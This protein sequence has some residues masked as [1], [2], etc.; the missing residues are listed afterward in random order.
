MNMLKYL[1]SFIIL[2]FFST[3]VVYADDHDSKKYYDKDGKKYHEK[4]WGGKGKWKQCPMKNKF[5]QCPLM[6]M[7]PPPMMGMEGPFTMIEAQGRLFLYNKKNG[8]V[9][10]CNAF[11]KSC[12]QVTVENKD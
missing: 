12:E 3:T 11:N 6:G 8:D 7:G 9:W 5:G 2:L 4:M 10:V 1:I